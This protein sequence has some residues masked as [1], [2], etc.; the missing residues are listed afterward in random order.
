MRLIKVLRGN[1]NLATVLGFTLFCAIGF[2]WLWAQAGGTIPF[3]A[4]PGDYRV[5]FVTDDVKNLR[6]TGDV[7]VAGITVGR[8]ESS[9]IIDGD[10]V[11][12][13]LSLDES[14]APL[15]DGV[16][17]RVGVKSL[18]GS[19]YID[20]V[21]GKGARL[22]SGSEIDAGNVVPAVDVDELLETLDKPTRK[23]LTGLFRSLDTATRHTGQEVDALMTGLGRVGREGHTVLDAL[24]AQG[25]DLTALTVEVRQ[26]LDALDTGQGQIADLVSDAQLLTSATADKKAE[27]EHLVREM[28]GLLRNVRRGAVSLRTLSGPLHPI[29]VSLRKASPDLTSALVNLP[30]VT[31]DLEGVLPHLDVTLDRLPATLDELPEFSKALRQLIPDSRLLLRDVN[32]TLGYLAPYGMDLGAMLAS[33]GGSFDTVAE[34]GIRPIRLTATSEGVATVK[35]NPVDLTNRGTWWL[36]PYP[37]PLSADKPAPYKGTYPRLRRDPE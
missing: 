29:L 8:V 6:S 23:S 1:S 14:A 34:D 25:D 30:S 17:V 10:R 20:V 22:D 35:G 28:P 5:S 11:R 21:D 4:E 9:E 3:L 12:V 15:H 16:T 19:S 37:E 7:K 18:V 33:F 32:P 31:R 36:N 13:E 27:I 2:G 26:L 24:A